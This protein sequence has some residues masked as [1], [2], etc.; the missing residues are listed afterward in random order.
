VSYGGRE[1]DIDRRKPISPQGGITEETGRRKFEGMENI[2]WAIVDFRGQK[3]EG[4]SYVPWL[5]TLGR[6]RFPSERGKV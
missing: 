1:K 4:K 6:E 2:P 5:H 3:G